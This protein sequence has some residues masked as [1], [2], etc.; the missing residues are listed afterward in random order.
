MTDY[1]TWLKARIVEAETTGE[2]WM[3]DPCAILRAWKA[4]QPQ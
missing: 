4:Q 1:I 2:L 3:L